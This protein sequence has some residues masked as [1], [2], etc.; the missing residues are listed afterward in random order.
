MAG[1]EGQERASE[2]RH[3][4]DDAQTEAVCCSYLSAAVIKRSDPEQQ[5]LGLCCLSSAPVNS[6]PSN[7]TQAPWCWEHEV[8]NT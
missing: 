8:S 6:G 5:L 2:Q 3:M 7:F 4:C 1:Q